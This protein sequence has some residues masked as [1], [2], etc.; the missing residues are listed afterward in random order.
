MRILPILAV[1][2]LSYG[3]AVPAGHNRVPLRGKELLK[4]ALPGFK[5]IDAVAEL[6]AEQKKKAQQR[7]SHGQQAVDKEMSELIEEAKKLNPKPLP[8][9]A[10]HSIP[11]INSKLGLDEVL[12]EGDML[13]TLE[14]AK[15]HFGLDSGRSK[16][17]AMQGWDWPNSLWKDGVYYSYSN[18]LN[19]K[20]RDAVDKAA[21]F[22]QQHTCIRFYKV[23][24]K[25][26]ARSSPLLVFYPRGGGCLSQ[27]GR[28]P[29]AQEQ[30][31]SI[32]PGCETV[33]VAAHEIGHALGFNHEQNR[34]DRGQFVRLNLDD[35]EEKWKY[36]YDVADKS[37]NDNYGKQYDFRGIMHYFDTAFAKPNKTVMFTRNPAYQMSLGGSDVPTYGDIFEM[38]TQY[39]CY[40]RCKNSGTVCKNEG[41]PNPNNCGVCQCP[42]GF[43]GRDCSQRQPPSHGLRCGETLSATGSWKTLSISNVVGNGK[44]ESANKTDPYHCTWHVKAPA[45]KRIQYSVTY[46]GISDS[47]GDSLCYPRCFLGGLSIKGIEKTWIPEG[48]RVCCK[49][50]FNKAQTTA[51]N[52]LI[53]QPWNSFAYTDFKVQYKIV[54]GTGGGGPDSTPPTQKT[55]TTTTRRPATGKCPYN[56]QILSADGSRCYS[57]YTAELTYQSAESVCRNARGSISMSQPAQDEATLKNVFPR[58]VQGYWHEIYS[59]GVCGIYNFRTKA[60]GYVWCTDAYSKAAF[61]CEQPSVRR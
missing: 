1:L 37:Q 27:I 30:Y 23:A 54:D 13:L 60:T 35:A 59:N 55:T 49:T 56:Y 38:N 48:M 42:S 43:G 15:R 36:A 20:G 7:L 46:V 18:D 25:A 58:S 11:E 16:R 41:R 22:W 32:G 57:Y 31:V 50:Q 40:D 28:D 44:W 4:K 17:Q 24:S 19:Q 61:I 34:W 39:S 8:A 6:I 33:D 9:N 2:F 5:D 21:A 14:Q 45:G 52:L 53:I 29:R 3:H 47:E 51:S 10:S 26:Q 12:V